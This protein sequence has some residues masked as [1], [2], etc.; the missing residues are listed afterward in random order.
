VLTVH[1]DKT[2]SLTEIFFDKALERA[3]WLD[4]YFAKEGKTIGPLHGLPIT[5][6]VRL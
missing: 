1:L 6:K 4:D 5:L 2:N 3:R